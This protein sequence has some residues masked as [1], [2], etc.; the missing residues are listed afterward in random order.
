MGKT[1]LSNQGGTKQ[2][3]VEISSQPGAATDT[4]SL[5]KFHKQGVTII[6]YIFLL[7]A[8]KGIENKYEYMYN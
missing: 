6:Y 4:V 7:Y 8:L 1:S 2:I 5:F 3:L